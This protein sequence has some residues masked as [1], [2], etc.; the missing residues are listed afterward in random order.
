MCK[1]V[2]NTTRL[3]S[4]AFKKNHEKTEEEIQAEQVLKIY[5]FFL[6]KNNFF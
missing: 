2:F 1:D 6:N 3:N 4:A 5:K